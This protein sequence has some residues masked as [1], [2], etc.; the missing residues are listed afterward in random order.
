MDD[1]R[2]KRRAIALVLLAAACLAACMFAMQLLSNPAAPVPGEYGYGAAKTSGVMIIAGP[3][4]VLWAVSVYL[5]CTDIVVSRYLE[6]IA[7]LF[8]FWLLVVLLKYQISDDLIASTLWYLYYVPMLFVPVLCLFS[9]FRAATLDGRPSVRRAKLA[10]MVVTIALLLTVLTNNMHHLV[11]AFDFT[12][13]SWSADYR[14]ELGYWVVFAW[15]SLLYAA[16]FAVLFLAAR[17]QLRSMI[18]PVLAVG[19]AGFLYALLYI[20]RIPSVFT[21]N[22]SLGYVLF[23]VAALELCLDFGILPSYAWHHEIFRTLPFD[24]KVLSDTL[25]P[26][27][28][29][30]CAEPLSPIV[31]ETLQANLPEGGGSATFRVGDDQSR[32][33]KAYSLQGGV[34]LLTESMPD[35]VSRRDRLARKQEVLRHQ[36]ATLA[37]RHAIEHRLHLQECEE[38]MLQEVESS[39]QSTVST[40]QQMIANLPSGQDAESVALRRRRL[41]TIK[42]LVAYCKRKGA[43]VLSKTDEPDFDRAR[44]QLA[45]NESAADLRSI[46]IDCA[47]LVQVETLLPVLTVN[48][49]YDCFYDFA[50][51]ALS[52][53]KPVLMYCIRDGGETTVELKVA[54][55]FASVEEDVFAEALR[56]LDESLAKR[57]VAYRM[58]PSD[59]AVNLTVIAPKQV[60]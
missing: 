51:I 48:M 43:L 52:A 35:I 47:V 6:T 50:A 26:G 27:F 10:I 56:E 37:K 33:Y 23:V 42:L 40:I 9:A 41:L 36:N 15:F 55:E 28:E 3:L 12:N 19:I 24:L 17:A 60:D 14:Y 46:G 30:D 25:E 22:L 59:N 44:L 54:L 1:A 20:L 4:L 31:R 8:A 7:A 21:S 58:S 18:S 5:R 57:N 34:V 39:L 45:T 32:V 38:E 2:F 11:F 13:P 16:F 49:L 53:E 29:T